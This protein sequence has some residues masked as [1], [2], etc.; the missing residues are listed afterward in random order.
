MADQARYVRPTVGGWLRPLILGTFITTYVSV[1]IHAFVF[2]MGFIGPWIALAIGLLVG[3]AWATVY[4]LLLG[5]IDLCL[6]WLKLRRLP[7]GWSGW[8]NAAASAF[9]VHVVYAIVKPHSFYKL[10]VWGIVAAIAVPMLVAAIG[11]RVAGG[12]KI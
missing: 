12:K 5:L 9:A 7:V 2:N 4:A 3:T 6:L 11:A 8:L 1:A 10:G